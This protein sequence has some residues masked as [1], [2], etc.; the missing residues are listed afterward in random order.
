[1]LNSAKSEADEYC[2]NIDKPLPIL[3]Y[4]YGLFTGFVSVVL[5]IGGS[6]IIILFLR[7]CNYRL[8]TAAA[9]ASSIVPFLALFGAISYIIAGYGL[10]NLPDYCLGFVYLPV[11]ISLIIG[12]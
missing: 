5:G 8:T 10:S 9:I 11:A 3:L 7:G 12:S 2:N 1:M 4:I 6:I